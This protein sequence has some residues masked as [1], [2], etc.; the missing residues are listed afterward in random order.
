MSF[1]IITNQNMKHISSEKVRSNDNTDRTLTDSNQM[2]M[3][4]IL[5]YNRVRAITHRYNIQ[6]F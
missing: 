1:R 2:H 4:T 6:P 5:Y 3:M